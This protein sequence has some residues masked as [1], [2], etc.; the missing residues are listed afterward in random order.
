[1]IRIMLKVRTNNKLMYQIINILFKENIA[2]ILYMRIHFNWLTT[3]KQA[4]TECD[5]F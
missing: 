1:M 4:L 5:A 2:K 3:H